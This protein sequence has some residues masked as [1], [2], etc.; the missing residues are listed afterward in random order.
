MHEKRPKPSIEI[1]NYLLFL[2]LLIANNSLKESL[3]LDHRD[4]GK[5]NRFALKGLESL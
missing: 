5:S 4:F 3:E 1:E 2:V